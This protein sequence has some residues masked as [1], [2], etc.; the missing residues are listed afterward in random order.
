LGFLGLPG[1]PLPLSTETNLKIPQI[2]RIPVL[3]SYFLITMHFAM[4]D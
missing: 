4:P 3:T 2:Q 1:F